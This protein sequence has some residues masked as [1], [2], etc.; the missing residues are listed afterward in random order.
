MVL[1]AVSIASSVLMLSACGVNRDPGT[2]VAEPSPDAV[3][4]GTDVCA[5]CHRE[6]ADRWVGSHHQLAMQA[7]EASTVL[8]DFDDAEFRYGDVT[9]RFFRRNDEFWISADGPDG[10]RAEYQVIWT[11]GVE[12][13]QQY[14]VE[15]GDGR[16]QAFSAAWDTRSA[17]AGGQRWFHLYPAETIDYQDPLH[18][19]GTYQRWNTMCADCHSTDLVKGYD[20]QADRFATQFAGINV[21]CEACHGPGSVHAADPAIRPRALPSMTRAW[22]F[23]ADRSI[24]TRDPVS[25]S[26]AEADVCAQCHSRRAQ[27]TDNYRPGDPLLDAYR[28]AMLQPELYHA[29]G[30]IL[31]EVYVYGSFL[32]S[33]MAAAGVTCSD[34]HE[35][36]SLNLRAEGN[37]L[38]G[39]CHLAST[40]DQPSHH[41]HETDT[42]AAR[43]T[44]CHMRTETYMV[45]D[46][47]RDHSFRVPRPDLSSAIGSP[48]AC[49]D[50]HN[51]QS[52]DWAAA[53]VAEWYPDGRQN[54]GHFG[55]ALYAGR[56]WAADAHS[57]L[58]QLIDDPAQPEIARATALSLLAERTSAPDISLLERSLDGGPLLIL[59]GID[60][61]A[62]LAPERRIDLVQRF[63]TDERRAIRIA[64]ARV[65]LP[66]RNQLSP[67]RQSDLDAAIDEYVAV[68]EFNSDR[69]E[70][71]LNLAGVAVDQGRYADAERLYLQ[72]IVRHPAVAALY[73][74]LSDLYR[75]LG[76]DADSERILRDGLSVNPE[77]ATLSFSLALAVVRAGRQL[78]ALPLFVD[79]AAGSPDQ[80]YYQ[81]LLAIAYNDSGDNEYALE[82]LRDT[83]ERFPGHAD[84]LFALATILRD[85]GEIEDAYQYAAR[86]A[87][88]LPDDPGVRALLNELEQRL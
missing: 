54:E 79:A 55:L 38:C 1:G 71:L 45:V 81:F 88:V 82:L 51:D 37:A 78:E 59:A 53:R 33:A 73:V 83:N 50:C 5:G 32:Q 31:D 70:G 30:Q 40:Y 44:S 12:P 76:R 39:Q 56:S 7:A 47:R 6:E 13:L 34:C 14:L 11:F 16:V 3:Y 60:A 21:G 77:D 29:D 9:A 57:Q 52:S 43:C 87:F 49:N 28:P 86:L 42:Q 66:A 64:A 19:T 46:P 2:P 41:Q 58:T 24:A 17:A 18:W 62:G 20:R 84:T 74:N 4:V 67:R 27:L 35:P 36:H 15:I 72:A 65:L 61:T 22:L 48:N 8:G 85:A 10:E 68:Q 75:V 69:P 80:P 26:G 63:L 23:E 25:A